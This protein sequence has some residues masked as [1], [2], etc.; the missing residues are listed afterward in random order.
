MAIGDCATER[1]KKSDGDSVLFPVR[2]CA[3][4]LNCCFPLEQRFST[5]VRRQTDVTRRVRRCAAGVW[6]EWSKRS[7]K[8]SSKSV[9]NIIF[10]NITIIK[11]LKTRQLLFL[12]IKSLLKNSMMCLDYFITLLDVPWFE[13]VENLY[14]GS[15]CI[16]NRVPQVVVTSRTSSKLTS[17]LLRFRY[18][19]IYWV[20]I[21]FTVFDYINGSRIIIYPYKT[22]T[23]T[24]FIYNF[25]VMSFITCNQLHGE[26]SLRN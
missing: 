12:M 20:M 23:I 22:H 5:V 11:L 14:L 16:H 10:R 15:R 8:N 9:I 13:K 18:Q 25:T 17:I 7:D 2:T 19:D 26:Q 1:E 21:C 24:I 6:G 3:S 4:V